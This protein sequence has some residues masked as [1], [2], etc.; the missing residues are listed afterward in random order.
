M[1]TDATFISKVRDEF[2]NDNWLYHP[3]PIV[4]RLEKNRREAIERTVISFVPEN[5]IGLDVGCGNGHIAHHITQKKKVT[6]IG[7]DGNPDLLEQAR[8]RIANF[9]TI[10]ADAR[11]IP[12]E[13]KVDFIYC[14]CILSHV[15]DPEKIIQ[16]FRRLIKESSVVIIQIPND[17]LLLFVKKVVKVLRLQFLF[18]KIELQ[19]TRDHVQ[20]FTFLKLSQLIKDTFVIRKKIAAG[21]FFL[22][23][24]WI[25]VLEPKSSRDTK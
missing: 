3:N 21:I 17:T 22:P 11:S 8:K 25:A 19:L 7:V 13:E 6:I 12:L 1:V 15:T 14:G 18:P 24:Y 5:A 20:P 9:S 10:M 23:F 16:E 2:H 4:R